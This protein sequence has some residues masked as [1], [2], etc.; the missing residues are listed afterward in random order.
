MDYNLIHNERSYR[1][2]SSHKF[3]EFQVYKAGKRGILIVVPINPSR[4]TK[5]RTMDNEANANEGATK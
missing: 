4:Q 2:M 3:C 1:F 5:G